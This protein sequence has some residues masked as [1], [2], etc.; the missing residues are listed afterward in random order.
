VPSLADYLLKPEYLFRP[1][2]IARR[3]QRAFRPAAG[4]SV[5][6]LPW[7]LPLRIRRD[8]DI[9]RALWTTG[10]YDLAVSEVLWRL[11]EPGETAADAG[12]N[13]GYMTSL[14]AARS[15]PGGVVRAYE[16]HPGV[17]DELA[18]NC[19]LWADDRIAAV[20]P[21]QLG[22]SDRAR[23]ARLVEGPAFAA[24]RGTSHV[25][26]DPAGFAVRLTTLDQEFPPGSRI[27]VLKVD[28]EGHEAAVLAGADR[29]LAAR[30]VRDVVYEEHAPGA[31]PASALLRS[32]GY[33]VF[34][35]AKSLPGP[36]LG[37][38]GSGRSAFA[39]PS[40][41][42]TVEPERARARLAP[43]GWDCLRGR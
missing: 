2:Q 12:A 38:P 24:N 17:F 36:L 21:R 28:V 37:E 27:G 14:M 11:L 30:A 23:E 25:A 18:A 40:C 19:R 26:D 6:L 5:V 3:L 4:E 13:I 10:V 31:G 39:P 1:S 42:A 33:A 15:G 8:D 29:L 32:R 41:L 22:L 16:P 35:I 43:R 9:G 34:G 7:G 20:E